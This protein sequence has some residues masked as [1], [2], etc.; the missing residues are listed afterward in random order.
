MIRW[1]GD[2]AGRALVP[3]HRLAPEA[4]YVSQIY[5]PSARNKSASQIRQRPRGHADDLTVD[6]ASEVNTPPVELRHDD[7]RICNQLREIESQP[8][9]SPE[10]CSG[11]SGGRSTTTRTPTPHVCRVTIETLP[12]ILAA[13]Q[14]TVP[15]AR[16]VTDGNGPSQGGGWVAIEGS[17]LLS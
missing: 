12:T 9:N 16:H 15:P 7:D 5:T 1:S 10:H 6:S 2:D 13:A 17:F 3:G 11:R 8:T 4:A 14:A